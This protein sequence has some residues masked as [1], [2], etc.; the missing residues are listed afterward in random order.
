MF[1]LFFNYLDPVQVVSPPNEVKFGSFTLAVL[2]TSISS[3]NLE[4]R[5]FLSPSA[6]IT[7]AEGEET[8]CLPDANILS[9]SIGAMFHAILFHLKVKHTSVFVPYNLRTFRCCSA[10]PIWRQLMFSNTAQTL[11]VINA[12]GKLIGSF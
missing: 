5:R 7:R 2:R 1:S 6:K 11:S 9:Y 12:D 4:N 10:T 3:P 8:R